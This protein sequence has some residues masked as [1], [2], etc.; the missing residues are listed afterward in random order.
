MENFIEG[1]SWVGAMWHEVKR[2]ETGGGV[3]NDQNTSQG[4]PLNIPSSEQPVLGLEPAVNSV[5]CF[6][7]P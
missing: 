3:C 6:L 7:A 1:S 2:K 4:A 5:I